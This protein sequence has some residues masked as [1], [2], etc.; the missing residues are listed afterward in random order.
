MLD[1]EGEELD[2]LGQIL[3]ALE[4][5]HAARA[6]SC[7]SAKVKAMDAL[8][9]KMKADPE[10]YRSKYSPKLRKLARGEAPRAEGVDEASQTS[11]SE[12]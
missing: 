10:Y 8:L 9:V 3:Y 2:A 6:P 12:V 7:M 1:S 5:E 11:S 4:H